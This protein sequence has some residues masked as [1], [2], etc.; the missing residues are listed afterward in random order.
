MITDYHA[1]LFANEL[2]LR[3]P[4]GTVERLAAALM[5]TRVDLNSHQVDAAVFA[6][7]SPLS[8]GALLADEVGLGKTIEAGILIAQRW[9]EKKRRILIIVPANLRKQWQIELEEKFS[10]SAKIL[11]CKSFNEAIKNGNLN[12][13][14]CDEIVI[15]SY[16]FARNKEAYLKQTPWDLAVID[17]AHRLRN[18]YKSGN[19]MGTS[20]KSSLQSAPKI[21]LTATPLQ[22]NLMELYGLVGIIDPHVFG[23]EKS[24]RELFVNNPTDTTLADLRDRLSHLCKRTL[25]KQVLKYIKYTRG[26][27]VEFCYSHHLKGRKF[28][29]TP[30]LG[31]A[32][33]KRVD[34]NERRRIEPRPSICN[35][36]SFD[37]RKPFVVSVS[38]SCG[39]PRLLIAFSPSG[40]PSLRQIR[41][42]TENLLF[43]V[44]L[45]K[46]CKLPPNCMFYQA[47]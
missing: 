26:R 19:K 5:N 40:H 3:A 43:L 11:E 24:F 16:A 18:V 46:L 42:N 29:L 20:I 6:F 31:G 10:L 22:N 28:T 30:R 45:Y 21:L 38:F 34:F 1:Q 14:N 7:S 35:F 32:T 8:R 27:R 33:P 9:A 47:L 39:S 12:P 25:R 41:L 13:F 36:R 2:S 23:D 37:N 44:T 17:E 4:L 15:T